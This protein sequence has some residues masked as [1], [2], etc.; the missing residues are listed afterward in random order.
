VRIR[1]SSCDVNHQHARGRGGHPWL[2]AQIK[3][4]IWMF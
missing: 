1:A 3:L 2:V 4:L